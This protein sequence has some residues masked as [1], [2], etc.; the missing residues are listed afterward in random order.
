MPKPVPTVDTA[1][2]IRFA[3]PVFVTL[4]S[5]AVELPTATLPKFKVW[6]LTDSIADPVGVE[7][8]VP[9][10]LPVFDDE[11][12]DEAVDADWCVMPTQPPVPRAASKATQIDS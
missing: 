8:V 11:D 4:T 9:L 7:F 1:E 10:V 6:L 3:L 2:T 5:C 12:E